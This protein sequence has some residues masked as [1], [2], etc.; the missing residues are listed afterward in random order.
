M[1]DEAKIDEIL[2]PAKLPLPKSP[3]ARTRTFEPGSFKENTGGG[4]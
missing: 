3:N 2:D 1:V 4:C